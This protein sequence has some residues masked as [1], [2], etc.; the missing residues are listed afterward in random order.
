[1]IRSNA[2]R[3]DLLV[4]RCQYCCAS[5]RAT[6]GCPARL[7]ARHASGANARFARYAGRRWRLVVPA[8]ICLSLLAATQWNYLH[9]YGYP[10]HVDDRPE[11]LNDVVVTCYCCL[12]LR[13]TSRLWGW[14]TSVDLPV[15]LR[16]KLYGFYASIFHADLDEVEL[17]LSAFPNLVEFFV[18]RL[19]HGARPIAQ[20]ANMTSPADG[21]VLY[22]GPVTSCRV[23]QVKG[24][25][26]DLRQF[27][28]DPNDL[29]LSQ[30]ASETT[31]KDN[32]VNTLLKNPDNALYQLI[33]YLAPGDYHRFHSPA[34][35]NIKFRRHFPG[36]LLSVNPRVLKYMPNLFSLNERVVYVGEWAGG[37]MAYAAVG[38]TNV[39]SIRVYCDKGLATNTVHWPETAH[40]EEANLG[41]ARVAKGE[42][43]GE[44]RLGSTIVLLFEA[45]RDFQFSLQI[46][47]T[48]KVGQALSALPTE[49]DERRSKPQHLIVNVAQD[50]RDI[51]KP[52]V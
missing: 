29:T 44:F 11:L 46:G 9:K 33:V 25:T 6:A 23:E 27:L 3:L 7:A 49:S 34:D 1:M 15:G 31:Q 50:W 5:L 42:L 36:K 21:R 45:P 13:T 22:F 32:Y 4:R 40:W 18:R 38:A 2:W 26:Y 8:G 41:C 52:R 47:Q 51:W 16:P 30:I 10:V 20:H 48:I 37:F 12:P 43:F 14:L 17:D 28:G 39:G 24:A 19:K 35:W